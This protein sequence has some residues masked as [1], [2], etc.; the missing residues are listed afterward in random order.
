MSTEDKSGTAAP[1]PY[2][3]RAFVGIVA[4]GL[5]SLLWGDAALRGVSRLLRPVTSQLPKGVAE[6]LPS[7]DSGWRIYSVNPPLPT[8][9]DA[10]WRLR[11]DGLVRRPIELTYA[12]LRALPG[13]RQVSDFHCVTGWSV[14]DVGWNGVRFRE[15]LAAASPLP[16]AGALQF[17]SA[18]RPYVDSLTLEQALMPDAMLALDIDGKPLTREHGAPARVVMPK[19]YGYKGVKWVNQITVTRRAQDGFWEQ[20]GYDRDAWIGH[21][22]GA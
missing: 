13:A 19:M 14:P 17:V 8:F 4:T 21:S 12:D 18:E 20:R 7:P 3:R 2:G 15:L 1:K 10:S 5:S 11:I 16:S 6:A 9:D 22:N